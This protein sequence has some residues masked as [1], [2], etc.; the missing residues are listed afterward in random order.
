M[1]YQR[2]A[3]VPGKVMPF[4][5]TGRAGPAD[6]PIEAEGPKIGVFD[7]FFEGESGR[8][9]FQKSLIPALATGRT[10][11]GLFYKPFHTAFQRKVISPGNIYLLKGNTRPIPADMP[12]EAKGP[13]IN[14]FD[15]F[16]CR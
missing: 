8:L 6:T 15:V 11:P 14:V 12:I 7:V 16:F 10:T 3:I 4:K 1:A 9:K 2:N 5:G 13:K